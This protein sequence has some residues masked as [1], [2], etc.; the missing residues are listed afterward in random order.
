M[1]LAM[2]TK[3]Q[4]HF[5]DYYSGSET[6]HCGCNEVNLEAWY[7]ATKLHEKRRV[8]DRHEECT[9]LDF[10]RMRLKFVIGCLP[11]G[12]AMSYSAI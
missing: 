5:L 4:Q 12:T 10:L 6:I 2:L 1:L 8:P 7:D 3:A 11:H 9:N